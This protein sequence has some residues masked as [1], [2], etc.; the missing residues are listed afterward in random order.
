M[1]GLTKK[2]LQVLDYI[3]QYIQKNQ[4]SPSY[5]EIQKKFDYSS[6]GTVFDHIQT[7]KRKGYLQSDQHQARSMAI[8][9]KKTAEILGNKKIPVI[10]TITAGVPLK[11]EETNQEVELPQSLLGKLEDLYAFLVVGEGFHDELISNGDILIIEARGKAF[12]HELAVIVTKE[13]EVLI[14]KVQYE[15]SYVRLVG[16]AHH[17]P[18]MIFRENDYTIYGIVQLVIRTLCH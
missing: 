13:E 8:E 1:Q 18:A 6:L 12:D 9:E 15:G 14:K 10:G 7:L 5:R 3:R 4:I 2:Q 11:V 17:Q 16:L